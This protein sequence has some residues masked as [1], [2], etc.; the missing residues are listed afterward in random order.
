MVLIPLKEYQFLRNP[1]F[2]IHDNPLD[3]KDCGIDNVSS[4]P[5]QKGLLQRNRN[6]D[7]S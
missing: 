4:S 6:H 5:T 2:S 1:N 7:F 3:Q